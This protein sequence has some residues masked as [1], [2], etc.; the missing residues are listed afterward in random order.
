MFSAKILSALSIFVVT[1]S[2]ATSGKGTLFNF[3]PGLGACG[4]TNTSTELVASVSAKNFNSYPGATS[5]PNKNP[6]CTHKLTV[7]LGDK[8]YSAK[9]VDYFVAQGQDS[10]VGFSDAAFTKFANPSQGT[11]EGVS[12]VIV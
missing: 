12:W 10:D 8:H 6:I 4:F 7:S 9:I 11:V 3:A 5:N 1:A 2:A